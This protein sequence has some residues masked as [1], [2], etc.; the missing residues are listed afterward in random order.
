MDFYAIDMAYKKWKKENPEL[1]NTV[2][3]KMAELLRTCGRGEM[4]WKQGE[5][6]YWDYLKRTVKLK[7]II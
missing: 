5:K 6:Y 1:N 7:R 2:I 3:A 4:T